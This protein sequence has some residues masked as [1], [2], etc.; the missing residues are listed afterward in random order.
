MH[1]RTCTRPRTRA[2]AQKRARTHIHIQYISYCSTTT[3]MVSRTR[4]IVTSYV[5]C[6][7]CFL[8]CSTN[9]VLVHSSQ[10]CIYNLS[11]LE[12]SHLL[13]FLMCDVLKLIPLIIIYIYV[14][15]IASRNRF[16]DLKGCKL[17]VIIRC[18]QLNEWRICIF[19]IQFQT[20]MMERLCCRIYHFEKLTQHLNLITCRG[21]CRWNWWCQ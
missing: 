15:L 3:T 11:L 19:I 2:Q 12:G 7:S 6:L 10:M 21:G 5:H 1:A 9:P 4:L 14:N 17:N 18:K 20:W 16:F 13:P 8:I